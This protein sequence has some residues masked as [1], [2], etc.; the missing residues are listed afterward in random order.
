MIENMRL[1]R[2]HVAGLGEKLNVRECLSY[3]FDQN[4]HAHIKFLK[5]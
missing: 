3:E 4:T 2:E 5:Q 1:R